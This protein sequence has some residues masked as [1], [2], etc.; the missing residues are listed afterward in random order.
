MTNLL[1]I[2]LLLVGCSNTQT[3]SDSCY[4]INSL[5]IIEGV[6]ACGEFS[7]SMP[8]SG[9]DW[10]CCEIEQN[11]N[12][13][14]QMSLK[15]ACP[16]P[17]NGYTITIGYE[18][19]KERHIYLR[20]VNNQGEILTTVV[21]GTM[22]AGSYSPPVNFSNDLQSGVYRVLLSIDNSEEIFC[23]GDICLCQELSTEECNNVCGTIGV[24]E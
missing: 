11:E 20:I 2:L 17:F 23:Y 16:N 13:Y 12:P 10:N 3:N 7:D 5:P 19:D 15:Y 14:Y 9:D 6:S 1:L 24:G 8:E 4:D 21:N 18:L 22:S